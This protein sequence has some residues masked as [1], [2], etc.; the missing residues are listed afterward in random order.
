MD[1]QFITAQTENHFKDASALMQLYAQSL[2]VDLCFQGFNEELQTLHI[3]Y[4]KPD[5]ELIVAYDS[6]TPVGCVAVR[7]LQPEIAELKRMFVLPDYRNL[8]LRQQ[9]LTIIL[10]ATKR[11]EYKKIRLDTLPSMTTAQKL[12]RVNGFYEIE[13]YRLN[14]VKGVV[15]MEREV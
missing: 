10:A 5:G 13:S 6:I 15:Y 3:Q 11:L 4:N 1:I 14:P 9:I 2:E 12:Y 7:K 8:K